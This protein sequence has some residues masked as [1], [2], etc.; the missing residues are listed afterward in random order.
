M[1]NQLI[2]YID[3]G[4]EDM[5]PR[6][7]LPPAYI[8]NGAIYLFDYDLIF[9]D[10]SLVS[11]DCI[12]FIMNHECSINIDGFSDLVLAEYYLNLPQ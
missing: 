6:Q 11:K 4:F 8:R 12:P 3:T 5:R 7:T 2:N 10:D 1:N 9:E